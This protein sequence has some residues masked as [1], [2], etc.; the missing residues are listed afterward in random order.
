M[1]GRAKVDRI[2][3][4]MGGKTK[5]FTERLSTKKIGKTAGFT[6]RIADSKMVGVTGQEFL[7]KIKKIRLAKAAK[8]AAQ[9]TPIVGSLLGP[10][11]TLALTGDPNEALA[12][13]V[14]SDALGEGSDEVGDLGLSRADRLR[15]E[16]KAIE[17]RL[18]KK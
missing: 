8:K 3:T 1:V 15:A 4:H 2:K 7:E 16:R 12:S 11:V 6:E 9:K 10:A 5:P 13:A 18:R 14:D 17:A